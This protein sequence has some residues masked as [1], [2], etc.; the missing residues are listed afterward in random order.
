MKTVE[1]ADTVV[2]E[3]STGVTLWQDDECIY[4]SYN[5]VPKLMSHITNLWFKHTKGGTTK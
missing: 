1:V 2:I 3:S 4:I 5:D